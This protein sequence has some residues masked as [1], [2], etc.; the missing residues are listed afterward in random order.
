MT[1]FPIDVYRELAKAVILQA[2]KDLHKPEYTEE[3]QSAK[4]FLFSHDEKIMAWRELWQI[5]AFKK[6]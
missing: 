5:L 3:H 4:K 2:Q 1:R 6:D